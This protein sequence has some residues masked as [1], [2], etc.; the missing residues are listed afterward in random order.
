MR[1]ST[2]DLTT[3][4]NLAALPTA[5]YLILSH[6]RPT[7]AFAQLLTCALSFAFHATESDRFEALGLT[8][9]HELD[10]A[11]L[12]QRVIPP[13]WLA[14]G[15]V[16]STLLLRADEF[17][18]L[19]AV[20]GLFVA[21]GGALRTLRLAFGRFRVAV[22]PALAA[23]VTSDLLLRGWAHAVVHA[24]WHVCAFLLTPIL[25][26]AAEDDRGGDDGVPARRRK[27]RL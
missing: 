12:V 14:W 25:L 11:V 8:L 3:L 2:R 19:L 22:L 5:T 20:G 6:K 17:G 27:R 15:R 24:L 7:L 9:N 10:D 26:R 1:A 4:S 13:A 23:L 18:A 21:C 16:H